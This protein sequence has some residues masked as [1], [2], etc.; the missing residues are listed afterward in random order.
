MES[1][2]P[3]GWVANPF[4]GIPAAEWPGTSPL[5]GLRAWP[6]PIFQGGEVLAEMGKF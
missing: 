6:R 4:A 5:A 2:G 1:V 3:R